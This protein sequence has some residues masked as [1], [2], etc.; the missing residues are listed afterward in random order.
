MMINNGVHSLRT[1]LRLPEHPIFRATPLSYNFRRRFFVAASLTE[2][3]KEKVIV[4]SGPTGSGK[5]RL[6]MELAKI[7]NGE[8]VSADSVQVS[9]YDK[10]FKQKSILFI[11]FALFEVIFF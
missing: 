8:I 3:K 9:S 6:A 1:C 5:S 7:I 11:F 4:I 2:K 10:N